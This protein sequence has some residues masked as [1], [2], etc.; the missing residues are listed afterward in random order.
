[1]DLFRADASFGL[2][3]G[4]ADDLG[5]L[6]GLGGDEIAEIRRRA[7]QRRVAEVGELRL[8]PRIGERGVDLPVDPL[9]DLGWRAARRPRPAASV[10]S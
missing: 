1:L 9:D 7:R 3:V 4:G 2:E 5:P 8:D 10:A 6:L